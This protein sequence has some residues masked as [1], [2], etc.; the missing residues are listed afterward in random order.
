MVGRVRQKRGGGGERERETEA[1]T[2]PKYLAK[3]TTANV[4]D[5]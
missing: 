5:Q 2:C 3:P 4:N 1:I